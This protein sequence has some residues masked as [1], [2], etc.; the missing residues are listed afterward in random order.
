MSPAPKPPTCTCWVP[1][2]EADPGEDLQPSIPS[3]LSPNVQFTVMCHHDISVTGRA[4]NGPANFPPHSD[5][6]DKVPRDQSLPQGTNADCRSLTAWYYPYDPV[7]TA[8]K[9]QGHLVSSFYRARPAQSLCDDAVPTCHPIRPVWR[10]VSS[11]PCRE[12]VGLLRVVS[13]ICPLSHRLLL[14]IFVN[15]AWES[16]PHQWGGQDVHTTLS[17]QG[18]THVSWEP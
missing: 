17:I 6:V 11:C 7:P 14:A 15:E 5:P 12:R 3:G 13:L 2:P 8:L 9:T 10:E 18:R 1:V 16:L 4:W